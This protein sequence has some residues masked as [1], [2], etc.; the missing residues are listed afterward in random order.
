M[1]T[2][3]SLA[4]LFNVVLVVIAVGVERSEKGEMKLMHG[5]PRV[6]FLDIGDF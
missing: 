1:N 6:G 4:Q 5:L 2:S 3:E